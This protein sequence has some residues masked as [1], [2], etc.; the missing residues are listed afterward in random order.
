MA[1]V[2]TVSDAFRLQR[3]DMELTRDL[4]GG[5]EAMA[6]AAERYIPKSRRFETAEEY[7][8]RLKRTV[9]LN[10]YKR[11]VRFLRGQVFKR[12][13]V[14]EERKEDDLI[15]QEQVDWFREW[16]EDVNL[17]GDSINDWSGAVFE[18]G[19]ND[20]VTFCLVD[21]SSVPTLR[22]DDGKLYYMDDAGEYQLK[23]AQADSDHGWRPYLVHVPAERVI[24]CHVSTVNGVQV[25]THFRYVEDFEVPEDE[26]GTERRQRIRVFTP[27][28]FQTWENSR[29]GAEDYALND[30]LSGDMRDENGNTLPFVPVCIFMP[31]DRRTA[32]TAEPALQDLA[33]LNKRHWQATSAQAELMEFV[34]RPVWFGRQLG[35]NESGEPLV[36]GAGTLIN[37]TSDVADLRNIGID[38]GS[39]TAGREELATLESQ[40]ALYG[41]QLLQPASGQSAATATE[42]N[43]DT[44]ESVSTLQDWAMRFQNFLENCARF[45][46][47]WRGWEDGPS[48]KV[49][50]ELTRVVNTELLAKLQQTGVISKLSLLELLKRSGLLPDDFDAE[51]ELDRIEQENR[52]TE[53]PAGNLNLES[54]LNR[55]RI[56]G[57]IEPQ[58]EG[59]EAVPPARNELEI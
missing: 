6:R 43:Q 20:G 51:A 9:L 37:A 56:R 46:A 19:I 30:A 33:Q 12:P 14:I 55:D 24:D 26:W 23:T 29:D 45:V 52:T 57:A 27:G 40:M 32:C 49:N 2:A 36:F 58:N 22:Q 28:R 35:E 17:Q 13:V 59:S 10:A 4:M 15:N 25:V 21:Y 41:L 31:G 38:P 16:A 50:T 8:S 1:T 11:T 47:L 3:H 7:E 5:T 54:L 18:A 42:V 44:E 48:V 53:G 34:R 39:V